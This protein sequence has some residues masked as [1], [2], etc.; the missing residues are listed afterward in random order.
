VHE[1]SGK[2]E[3]V[4]YIN[5]SFLSIIEMRKWGVLLECIGMDCSLYI[6]FQC[7]VLDTDV[8]VFFE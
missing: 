8:N 1:H 4:A 3:L 2:C 5:F 6:W 7:F